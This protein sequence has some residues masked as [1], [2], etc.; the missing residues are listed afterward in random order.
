M[1]PW[2]DH[3]HF[4]RSTRPRSICEDK[5][6]IQKFSEEGKRHKTPYHR[7]TSAKSSPP[8]GRR[9]QRQMPMAM[10]DAQSE[11]IH[12]YY[13]PFRITKNLGGV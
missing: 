2:Q 12:D 1:A 8:V 11:I 9:D 6:W 7:K 3:G 10:F 13:V 4:N 5:A